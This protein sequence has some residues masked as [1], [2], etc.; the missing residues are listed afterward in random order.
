MK[1]LQYLL[2]I[3]LII[4]FSIKFVRGQQ[5]VTL[6]KFTAYEENA[7]VYLTWT[8]SAG[9]TCNGMSILRSNDSINFSEISYIP[10]VC[11]NLSDPQTYYFTDEQP[12]KN[13][14]NFYYLALGENN[15]SD[16]IW[17]VVFD[18]GDKHYQLRPNPLITTATLYFSNPRNTTKTLQIYQLNGKLVFSEQTNQKYFEIKS[19]GLIPG[20]YLFTITDSKTSEI[21]NGRMCIVQH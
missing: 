10:G 9:S 18:F 15:R 19:D 7:K 6:D 1:L 17:V 11:G 12:I 8:L 21:I 2:L 3:F 16:V 20:L 4:S 5:A 13:S 14:K